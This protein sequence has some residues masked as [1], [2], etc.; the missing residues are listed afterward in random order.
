MP[1]S[2][3]ACLRLVITS[4][5]FVQKVL[6]AAGG[7]PEVFL[8]A[9]KPLS[10]G[11]Q[12]EGSIEELEGKLEDAREHGQHLVRPCG[13]KLSLLWDSLLL[14]IVMARDVGVPFMCCLHTALPRKSPMHGHAMPARAT[15][16]ISRS[17]R[18]V[19]SKSLA[20]THVIS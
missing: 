1:G 11:T 12:V 8:H 5:N 16:S 20:C 10:C 3:S 14:K 13:F 17:L 9:N 15:L 7:E 4:S 6:A 19:Q 2:C 18:L